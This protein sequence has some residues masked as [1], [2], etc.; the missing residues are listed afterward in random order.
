MKVKGLTAAEM[1]KSQKSENPLKNRRNKKKNKK[2]KKINV[3]SVK[4]RIVNGSSN[5]H[6]NPTLTKNMSHRTENQSELLSK[7][8]PASPIQEGKKKKKKNKAVT[9]ERQMNGSSIFHIEKQINTITENFPSSPEQEAKKKKIKKEKKKSIPTTIEY[10][11]EYEVKATVIKKGEHNVTKCNVSGIEVIDETLKNVSEN[12]SDSLQQSSEAFKWMTHPI[13][14]NRFFKKHWE[15]EPLYINRENK[16][17]YKGVFSTADLDKIL[18]EQFVQYT[19][20]LNITSYSDG[21]RET[22]DLEGRAHAPVVWDYYN[23]GCSVRMLN[24]QTFHKGVWKLLATLQEY[25]NSFCGA[26]VYLT[27]PGTQGFAPHWDDIEAF[28][29]QLEGK[30]HWKVYK[31]RTP[32]EVLPEYSSGNLEANDTGEVY[33][34]VILEPGDMLYFPRGWIHQAFA[35]E[36]THSL[37]IT[38]STYQKNSWGNYLSKFLPHALSVAMEEDVE[39]R[40]GLPRD[41]LNYMGIV[42]SDKDDHKDRTAFADKVSELVKRMIMNPPYDVA[43]DQMG[44]NFIHDCLPPF[45]TAEDK[46]HSIFGG[47]EHWSKANMKVENRTE[48]EPDTPIRL[49]RGNCIRVVAEEDFVKVY[50]TLENS[51]EYHAE[52][53][54]FLEVSP[55]HAPA[56]ECLIDQ[57]PNYITIEDLPLETQDEKMAF[58]SGLWE[59]GIV[60][61]AEPLIALYNE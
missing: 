44:V 46:E 27:P 16:D 59:R 10:N 54:K 31:P 23:N 5:G 26:N 56:V 22:H 24:P 57:Y 6:I 9:N 1:Y 14:V 41:Y 8:R 12:N 47:G 60:T 40:K 17:Y 61:T 28:I 15:K 13:K 7:K 3:V 19:K 11:K 25:F 38:V 32:E 21:K 52:D 35:L 4:G 20:N 29:L 39:F 37:H 50:H 42:H 30:K 18:R 51:R 49:I 53:S 34:D 43:A 55:E 45:L 48:L 36:D 33:M 2:N 58:A